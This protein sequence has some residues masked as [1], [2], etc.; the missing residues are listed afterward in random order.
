MEYCI[1]EPTTVTIYSD[2]DGEYFVPIGGRD[3]RLS[4]VKEHHIKL[5]D[6]IE[7]WIFH[8]DG[9]YDLKVYEKRG[10]LFKLV[11]IIPTLAKSTPREK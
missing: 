4:K 10:K 5:D 3:F 11:A 9:G 7:S 2:K 8:K 1:H 6:R